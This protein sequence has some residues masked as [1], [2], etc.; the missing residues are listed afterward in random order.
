MNCSDILSLWRSWIRFVVVVVY[1][2]LLVIALPLCVYELERKG[3][4]DHVQAWFVGGL[5]VMMALPISFMG[6]LQHIINYTTPHLQRHVI[7]ILWMVPIYAL[8]A[9][10]ALRF[11]SAA[12]Y[13]DTMRECYEAYVI[14]NFMAYL[15]AFLNHEYPH[16]DIQVEGKPPVHH[17]FPLCY[18]PPSK[19]YMKFIQRCKHGVLQYTVVRPLMTVIALI[20]EMCGKYE[21]GDFNFTTAWSYIVVINNLSQ[22]LAMYCLVLFYKAFKEELQPLKPVPKFLCVKAVVFLSFWQALFIAVLAKVG[23]IPENG[24]WVFYKDIKEVSTGLQDFMICIEMFL[25]SLAHYWS[26]SHKPFVNLAT[27]QQNFF[28][29][30]LSMWD[31]RDV[32]EDLRQHAR[33]VGRG[34]HKTLR[35]GMGGDSGREEENAPLLVDGEPGIHRS[36]GAASSYGSRGGLGKQISVETMQT[37][38]PPSPAVELDPD[39]HSLYG[40]SV[41]ASGR[42]DSFVNKSTT[43]SMN[44]YANFDGRSESSVGFERSVSLKAYDTPVEEDE[45]GPWEVV[46]HQ[47]NSERHKD[48]DVVVEKQHQSAK[49][50]A[51]GD[52]YNDNFFEHLDANDDNVSVDD[53][54][55]SVVEVNAEGD[56]P[57]QCERNDDDDERQTTISNS[58]IRDN[59][60]ADVG[61]RHGDGS[62][63][64]T[65]VTSEHIS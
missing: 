1:I 5:F 6:I 24:T 2:V 58:V 41:S 57:R 25:A 45:N 10:F 3:A 18:L 40:D 54:Q 13:L 12:I 38:G 32:T 8:N 29:S 51:G 22:I 9:W 20:S 36:G 56:A 46:G 14:Y 11:P 16:L 48:S 47:S 43:S 65:C 39:G 23:A 28:F 34:M 55:C 37:K 27:R 52:P 64:D 7:R 33:F 19:N 59:D 17:L 50:G 35:R 21:E 53:T 4:P 31:V 30:F 60:C 26:F 49:L 61:I 44:N 63:V 15:M 62:L 42:Y